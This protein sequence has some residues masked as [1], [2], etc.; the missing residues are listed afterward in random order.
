MTKRDLATRV[1]EVAAAG[2]ADEKL[3]GEESSQFVFVNSACIDMAIQISST[4][5]LVSALHLSITKLPHLPSP[6]VGIFRRRGRLIPVIDG[7]L[8][9]GGMPTSRGNHARLIVCKSP[10]GELGLIVDEVTSVTTVSMSSFREMASSQWSSAGEFVSSV[11][12]FKG[13]EHVVVDITR[14]WHYLRCRVPV[15]EALSWK[16]I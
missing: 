6:F 15:R 4:V 7:G 5:E 8:L 2:P 11:V 13:N 10:E 9:I 14:L 3:A 1:D 12:E 16:A